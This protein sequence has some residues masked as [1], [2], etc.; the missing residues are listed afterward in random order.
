MILLLLLKGS[1][2]TN[3]QT[4]TILLTNTTRNNTFPRMQ[5]LFFI[6]SF[7]RDHHRIKLNEDVIK[8]MV[9]DGKEAVRWKSRMW[10][11]F[12]DLMLRYLIFEE[13]W[14]WI[15]WYFGLGETVELG[16][17]NSVLMVLLLA[18]VFPE[19]QSETQINRKSFTIS[20]TIPFQHYNPAPE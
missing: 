19:S 15:L 10:F 3:I 4:N 6:R 16:I 5:F 17:G 12:L 13:S 1:L 2:K 8:S 11:L 9:N 7:S 14:G 18:V 20:S